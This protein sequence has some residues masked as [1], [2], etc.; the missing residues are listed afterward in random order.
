MKTKRTKLIQACERLNEIREAKAAVNKL[1]SEYD[2]LRSYVLGEM[3]GK[4]TLEAGDYL[5]T[6]TMKPK[7]WLD[8]AQMLADGINWKDYEREMKNPSF[9]VKPK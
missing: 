2:A 4:A 9:S 7:R 8:K 5:A 6:V 1:K 3:K